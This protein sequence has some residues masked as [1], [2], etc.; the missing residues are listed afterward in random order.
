MI[1]LQTALVGYLFLAVVSYT[2]GARLVENCVVAGA[3]IDA[4]DEAVRKDRI[5]VAGEAGED[6]IVAL[7]TVDGV[8]AAVALDAVVI[9]APVEHVGPSRA[10]QIVIALFAE[11]GVVAR[12]PIQ[13]VGVIASEHAVVARAAG[14][15]LFVS[16]AAVD[17]VVTGL[18]VDEVFARV[19]VQ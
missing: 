2:I 7:A 8:R 19:A 15:S 18:S 14:Q 9:V 13:P 5:G 3:A 1:R 17:G 4:I 10:V 16:G 11:Q 6:T 12:V